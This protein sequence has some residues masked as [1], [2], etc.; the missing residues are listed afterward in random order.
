MKHRNLI[1]EIVNEVRNQVS[2][3]VNSQL[4]REVRARAWNQAG[5]LPFLTANRV[6]SLHDEVNR[7]VENQV[8][9]QVRNQVWNNL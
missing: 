3:R 8:R 2:V 4:W 6:Q 9:N 5:I 1:N 7:R